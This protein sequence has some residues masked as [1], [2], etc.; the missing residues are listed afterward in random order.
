M[1][2]IGGQMFL[3]MPHR[4]QPIALLNQL[5]KLLEIRARY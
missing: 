5:H 3:G 4:L 2:L 1:I